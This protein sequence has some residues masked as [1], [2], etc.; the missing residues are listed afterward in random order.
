MANKSIGKLTKKIDKQEYDVEFIYTSLHKI[1]SS[2]KIAASDFITEL[3]RQIASIIFTG[4]DNTRK[5]KI[6]SLLLQI[7]NYVED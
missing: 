7:L 1:I 2:G 6:S 5:G 4:K 3:C